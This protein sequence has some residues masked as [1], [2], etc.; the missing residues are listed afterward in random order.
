MRNYAYTEYQIGSV[1]DG[2]YELWTETN[3][4]GDTGYP[5]EHA[6]WCLEFDNLDQV[7]RHTGVSRQGIGHRV[8]VY[9]DGDEIKTEEDWPS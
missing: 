7:K 2:K 5:G 9:L 6:T 4:D 1:G 3:D 8:F